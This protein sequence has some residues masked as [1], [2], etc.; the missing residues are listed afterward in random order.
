MTNR[1]RTLRALIASAGLTLHELRQSGDSHYRVAV[2]A[3]D[4]RTTVLFC[5]KTGSDRWGDKNLLADM[6]RFARGQ[7]TA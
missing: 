2:A 3:P 1:E 7:V 4:G 6:R 5:A